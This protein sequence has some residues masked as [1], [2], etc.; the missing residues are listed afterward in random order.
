MLSTIPLFETVEAAQPAP[1]RDF[2]ACE[3]AEV[4]TDN[5]FDRLLADFD[6]QHVPYLALLELTHTCNLDCVM[7]YNVPLAQPELTT[8]EWLDALEQM[9]AAGTLRLTLSGGEIL[10]RRDFFTIAHHARMLGFALDLKTN[11]TLIT[12]EIADRMA[13][14]QPVQVDISLLGATDSTFDAVAGSKH[15]FT[16]VLR[17]VQL[18]QQRG[19]AVKLNTLLLNLNVHERS[20]MVDLAHTLGV[21]YKHVVKISSADDGGNKAG[22]QQLAAQAISEVL[23][24]NQ[25]DF[26]VRV[27]TADTRTCKVGLSSFLVSPYGEVYP[28]QELRISAGNLR[29][30]SFQT[31]WQQAP[32]FQ[33]LRSRHTYA[34]FPE[35]RVCPINAYCIGRCSGLAWKRSGD[36]YGADLTACIQAQAHY[37]QRHPGQI[38]PQTPLQTKLMQHLAC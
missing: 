27:P 14:L 9:A 29:R 36:L 22:E 6:Q 7:C 24:A 38:A 19:V 18:L 1:A 26:R 13:D 10:T 11:A 28:C 31:I 33:E 35:C 16:R 15:T 25:A 32:I 30:Q 8:T 3:V 37:Q 5:A 4:A 12:P 23:T 17:G 34:N 20:Q 2:P 21:E